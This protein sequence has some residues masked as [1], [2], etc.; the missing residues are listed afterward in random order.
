MKIA[1]LFLACLLA[2]LPVQATADQSPAA[3]PDGLEPV[4]GMTLARL[5]ALHR[6]AVGA[7]SS[8][9]SHTEIE[10]WTYQT[11]GQTGTQTTVM[12]GE[13]FREDTAVGPFQSAQGE[14][15]GK[16]WL[17]NENGLTRY[18][19]GIHQ[20]DEANQYALAHA[21]RPGSGVELLGEVSAPVHAFV[22]KVAPRDGRVEYRFYDASNYLLIRDERAVEGRRLVRTYD[23]FR[24]TKGVREAWHI[25]ES[26]GLDN[27]DRDWRLLSLTI[28]VPVDAAKL[29]IPAS[30]QPL[31]LSADRV[32]IPVTMSGDRILVAVQIGGRKVNLQMDSGASGILL[33]RDV[34]D[35]TGVQSFG[36]RTEI[37]AGSYAASDAMIP[38]L[39]FGVATMKHVSAETSPYVSFGYGDE[40][41]AGLLGY[42][43]IAGAV[44]HVDY[45]HGTL[46]AI[47]P[48]SFTPPAG[49]IVLPIR[50]DD[51]VPVIQ[52]TIG[53]APGKYFIVDTG[54][55]RS[56]IFSAFAQAHP[57][58]VSDQGSGEEESTALPFMD[59]I[60]G[61]GGKVAVREVQVSSL[62]L[63]TVRLP[64]WL[65]DVSQDAPSF[66][67]DD[68]D[69]LI[70]QDVLRN[71]DVYFDYGRMKM[72]L[73][74][75]ERYRQRWGD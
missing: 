23:D 40:P 1:R 55:D 69:G 4:H 49:A 74:P 25:H 21:L 8:Q 60:Y 56:M 72:Y 3:P 7:P 24:V 51:G 15:A 70:G 29:A 38:Q 37:T 26:N 63:G 41:V 43:F 48:A 61:V 57:Q 10:T 17:H 58:D 71:F 46:E 19:S 34:A 68:Y 9:T 52:C 65:F 39:D 22:V 42:D 54:A 50:L 14:L 33:N 35:A 47:A 6:I 59:K 30:S 20:R 11:A 5:L 16:S 36:E 18:D 31:A 44:M 12:S 28:G 45:Y 53:S 66:E 62:S 73:L 75:N 67:G 32:S 13:D 27:D 2:A 64:D